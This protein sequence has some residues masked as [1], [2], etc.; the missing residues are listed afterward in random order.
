MFSLLLRLQ[1]SALN[2]LE[3][4][5]WRG[6]IQRHRL[7]LAHGQHTLI[8][9]HLPK[10]DMLPVQPIRLGACD[11]ELASVAV[12]SRIGHRQHPWFRVFV[13]EVLIREGCSVVYVCL[14]SA[15][16]LDE[17]PAL[18][19]KVFYNT[20]K[21]RVLVSYRLLILQVFSCAELTKVFACFGAIFDEE[22]NLDAS[23]RRLF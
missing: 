10:H 12:R 1:L 6:S 2:N 11:E 18:Y 3:R 15:I 17:I 21:Y 4:Q 22:L 23:Q 14:S 8:T 5:P 13:N 19:H 9:Q 16:V 7:A 20:M